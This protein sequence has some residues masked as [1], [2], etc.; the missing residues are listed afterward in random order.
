MD[1]GH[2]FSKIKMFIHHVSSTNSCTAQ[3]NRMVMAPV[4][5]NHSAPASME[6]GPIPWLP[7]N[8]LRVSPKPQKPQLRRKQ[9]S[10]PPQK[11]KCTAQNNRLI[12]NSIF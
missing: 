4:G 10:R 1:T 3:P 9:Q 8:A 2:H 12:T 6:M 7:Q 5:L 11:T